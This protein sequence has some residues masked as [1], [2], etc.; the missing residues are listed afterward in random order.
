MKETSFSL[1]PVITVRLLS[2]T[3][4]DKIYIILKRLYLACRY[5]EGIAIRKKTLIYKA[6]AARFYIV[7]GS[8][9]GVLSG[10]IFY[11]KKE[12]VAVVRSW[13]C[14]FGSQHGLAT[15][16]FT[17]PLERLVRN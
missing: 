3:L 7:A 12:D 13:R 2:R 15:K 17:K 4:I 14:R 16:G 8:R 1:S 10:A 9:I 5:P 6:Q 11:Q